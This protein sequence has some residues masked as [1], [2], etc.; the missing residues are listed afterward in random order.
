M[1][2]QKVESDY[3]FYK[4][5]YEE[6]KG[7]VNNEHEVLSN[8]LCDLAMQ[9]VTFKNELLKNV[10]PAIISQHNTMFNYANN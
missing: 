8:K 5:S 6:Q 10:K 2:D 9:F 1:K 4:K 3:K 7:V